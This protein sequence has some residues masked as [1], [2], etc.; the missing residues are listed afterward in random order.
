M[1][2]YTY[3]RSSASYRVRIGLNL[4]GIS[5]ESCPVH[6]VRDG[7]EQMG[8]AYT[9]VNP[10]QQVPALELD[11]GRVLIQSLAILEY[12]DELYP[13]Q[14][15]LPRDPVERGSCRALAL[16]VACDIHP[17]NN[18]R[19]LN[20]LTGKLGADENAKLT[21]YHHWIKTGLAS[22]ETL[23]AQ[24]NCHGPYSMGDT[25]SL[26]D[27]CLVPQLYNARRF[28]VDLSAYP[29]IRHIEAGCLKLSA[30]AEA[31]PEAQ[32]DAELATL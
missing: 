10:Q 12:L 29:L 2:L 1:K 27:I 32:E 18:L 6:L 9:A 8:E 23:L 28:N 25:L 11:D 5:Y 19:V 17:I 13:D 4:K 26:A 22:M 15:F 24:A 7:G 3:W 30:F 31:V 21:W 20:Y 16:L 14:P